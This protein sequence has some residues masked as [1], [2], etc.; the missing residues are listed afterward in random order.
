MNWFFV[1]D[2]KIQ[3]DLLK[4][5]CPEDV[6][7]QNIHTEA[8]YFLNLAIQRFHNETLENEMT[9]VYFICEER[10]DSEKMT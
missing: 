5:A 7:A 8:H 4:L 3:R 6:R 10:R 1:L 9:Y 2:A